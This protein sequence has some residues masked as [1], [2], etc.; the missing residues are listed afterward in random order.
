MWQFSQDIKSVFTE[1]INKLNRGETLE[2]E[3]R[4]GTFD[5]NKFSSNVNYIYFSRLMKYL[6]SDKNWIKS[7]ESSEISSYPNDVRKIMII[8][9]GDVS[10]SIYYQQKYNKQFI[11]YPEYNIRISTSYEKL[12]NSYNPT[13]APTYIRHRNRTTYTNINGILKIDMTEVLSEPN[14][15]TVS[16]SYEV[17]VEYLNVFDVNINTFLIYVDQISKVLYGTYNTFTNTMKNSL[18]KGTSKIIDHD[19]PYNTLVQ[20]RN[21]KFSDIKYGRIVGDKVQYT[22]THKA[23]GLRKILVIDRSG[24]WLIYPPYEYNLVE[25]ANK[26][27]GI[28][29]YSI[30]I[31][32]GEYTE[33]KDKSYE[34]LAFDSLL[35]RNINVQS[36]HYLVRHKHT[37]SITDKINLPFLKISTK[38]AS[39]ITSPEI[40]FS[41]V[42]KY[43]NERHTLPYETDGLMFVPNQTVYYPKDKSHSILKWKDVK[44]ITIDFAV[45]VINNKISLYSFSGGK[46]VPFLGNDI[47][48]ITPEIIDHNNLITKNIEPDTVVEYEWSNNMLRPRKLRLDKLKPNNIRVAED[49]WNDITRPILEDDIRGLN[50]KLVFNYHNEIKFNLYNQLTDQGV[51]NIIDIGS[52]NGGDIKKWKNLTNIIAIEPNK[53]N[54]ERLIERL[55]T[56]STN[57][58]KVL[59]L[60][61]EETVEIHKNIGNTRYDA[62]TLMLSM[63]FF[64][65]NRNYLDSLI[66]TIV[67]TIKPGGKI[68]FI[69]IDGDSLREIFEPIFSDSIRTHIK[70]LQA[71]I[72]LHPAP[73]NIIN[74]RVVDFN[75]PGTIVGNQREYLVMLSDFILRLN[76]HGFK[77]DFLTRADKEYLLPEK[78]AIY[79]SM[80]S[81]GMMYHDNITPLPSLSQISIPEQINIPHTLLTD[82]EPLSDDLQITRRLSLP[83]NT[84]YTSPIKIS[85]TPPI[86]L[87]I[88]E[89]NIPTERI[90]ISIPEYSNQP[91]AQFD[92]L[93]NES[94]ITTLKSQSIIDDI[95]P[96]SPTP[97][98]GI[99]TNLTPKE[100]AHSHIGI[101]RDD[102][103]RDIYAS[104]YDNTC[105][106]GSVGDGSCFVHCV[107]KAIYSV[108]QEEPDTNKRITLADQFR[109]SIALKLKEINPKYNSTYWS[110]ISNGQ[111]PMMMMQQMVPPGELISLINIDYSYEGLNRMF[112]S[113]VTLG[114]ESYQIIAELLDIN[115][116]IVRAINNDLI[117]HASG[118]SNKENNSIIIINHNSHYELLGLKTSEGIQ[119]LFYPNDPIISAIN[120]YINYPDIIYFDPYSTFTQNFYSV[121]EQ[122][123]DYDYAKFLSKDDPFILLY[124][125][126]ILKDDLQKGKNIP[127]KF[128]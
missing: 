107:L 105:R 128:K 85:Q 81:Y 41:L 12:L 93:P 125:N 27:V 67:T 103:V 69:T 74:G 66:N 30:T 70:L 111:F 99:V 76:E 20:S 22:V 96:I 127:P 65:K 87:N 18:I 116:I 2:L 33:L 45:K 114:D 25:N 21:I 53:E 79:S 48:K 60:G 35:I 95:N 98:S 39:L 5:K 57:K 61:G 88:P 44:D 120:K 109:Y 28:T 118:I 62:I 100:H 78:A 112:D 50:L 38:E 86:K 24:I 32:D 11:D 89:I 64:W 80:Y 55:K 58:V 91:I 40:F 97:E 14:N 63:S 23:D 19:N 106:I 122:N 42:N 51:K 126:T 36:E 90:Q 46:L 59:S 119:T 34:Y 10:E 47:I 56:S 82:V 1:K 17:E 16:N 37:K 77:M 123:F 13:T 29:D 104:W 117:Y 101:L 121:F 113:R 94:K 83:R 8:K 3:A 108:Y 9:K 73:N 54:R 49:N 110:T 92:T 75:I 115:I 26:L 102:Q 72:T 52:G 31:L 71:N 124:K 43:L 4:F 68:A 15:K 7:T 6:D 84:E